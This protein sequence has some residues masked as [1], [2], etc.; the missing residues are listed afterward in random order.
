MGLLV[1]G[2][3]FRRPLHIFAYVPFFGGIPVRALGHAL[4]TRDRVL[5]CKKER[6]SLILINAGIKIRRLIAYPESFSDR[7]EVTF[8]GTAPRSVFPDLQATVLRFD[9]FFRQ[10]IPPS[11]PPAE[12]FSPWKYLRLDLSCVFLPLFLADYVGTLV[13]S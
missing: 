13:P 8:G 9:L 12:G 4:V 6:F 2:T 3:P 7:M 11:L 10:A 5:S 1:P